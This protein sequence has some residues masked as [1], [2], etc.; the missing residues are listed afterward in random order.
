[1]NYGV[2]DDVNN[3]V[4]ETS[5][6]ER[7]EYDKDNI[8][9]NFGVAD[10]IDYTGSNSINEEPMFMRILRSSGPAISFDISMYSSGI[11]M[12]DGSELSFCIIDTGEMYDSE[13]ETMLDTLANGFKGYVKE[14]LPE[15]PCYDFICVE[16][17]YGGLSFDI[18]KKLLALNKVPD[19]LMREGGIVSNS[20]Y[21]KDNKEWKRILRTYHHVDGCPNDKVE[22]EAILRYLEFP[23]ESLYRFNTSDKKDRHQDLL[24]ALGLLIA[25]IT[26]RNNPDIAK[27]KKKV[28][29]SDYKIWWCESEEV[30]NAFYSNGDEYTVIES[31]KDAMRSI[32]KA[33]Q[34]TEGII[35]M[36]ADTSTLGAMAIDYDIPL[37]M[38]SVCIVVEPKGKRKKKKS[39]V[40]IIK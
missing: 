26:E 18:V 39:G 33:L 24:D 2:V 25:V 5:D 14:A 17:V 34:V 27:V 29:I 19:E 9:R 4:V 13:S 23:V 30:Y 40:S 38:N 22:I 15:N 32:K 20:L 35:I 36:E 6:T 37:D 28:K 8:N 7:Y 10:N 16:G 21:R 1:M 31:G 3:N 11:A 12:W